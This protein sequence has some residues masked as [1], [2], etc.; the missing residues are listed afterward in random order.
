M[1]PLEQ[2]HV[3]TLTHAFDF[4]NGTKREEEITLVE[5]E[6]KEENKNV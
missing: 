5:D 2:E 3:I 6:P 4:V 1:I